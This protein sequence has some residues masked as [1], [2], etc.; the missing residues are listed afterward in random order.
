[1]RSVESSRDA[2]EVR[3]I[4]EMKRIKRAKRVSEVKKK[5]GEKPIGYYEKRGMT[6]EDKETGSSITPQEAF[7]RQIAQSRNS[8][9][10]SKLQNNKDKQTQNSKENSTIEDKEQETER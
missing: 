4:D 6:K 7:R 9:I 1:M 3:P 10:Y 8:R 2:H 5:E